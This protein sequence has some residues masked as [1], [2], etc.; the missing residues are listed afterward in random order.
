MY[1]CPYKTF[2]TQKLLKL[3]ISKYISKPVPGTK[4]APVKKKVA[5]KKVAKKKVSKKKVARKSKSA[6]PGW[7]K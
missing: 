2:V 6:I 4:P 7:M 1:R 3:C 5:K